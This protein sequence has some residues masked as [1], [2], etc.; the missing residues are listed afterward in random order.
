V[1]SCRLDTADGG[2]C[3]LDDKILVYLDLATGKRK[4]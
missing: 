1:S 2:A 4:W 3:G